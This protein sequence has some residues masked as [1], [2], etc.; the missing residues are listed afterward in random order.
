MT[1][2]G[3]TK[4][5]AFADYDRDGRMDV[6]L[7]DQGGTGRLLHNVTPRGNDHWLEVDPRACGVRVVVHIDGQRPMTDE[8][9]CG[10][11]SVGSGSQAVAHFGLGPATR[12]DRLEVQWGPRRTTV[13]HD[14]AVDR[15]MT[16]KSP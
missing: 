9:A 1:D 8:V 6:F 16:V 7:L 3:D 11:T 15:L 10:G 12:V 13:L 14:V 5:A 2:A 4:G